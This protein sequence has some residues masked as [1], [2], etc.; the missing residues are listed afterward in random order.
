MNAD[1]SRLLLIGATTGYQTRTFA[2]AAERLGYELILATDRCHILDDPWADRAL[3]LRFEDPQGAAQAMAKLGGIHGI[4]AVG[5]RPAY[6]AALAAEKLGMAYNSVDSVAAC[7][8]K[9]LAHERFRAA[10]LLVPEYNR[11]PISDGPRGS[12]F[13]PC[14]LKPLGLSASRGVIRAN[15]PAEFEAA[16]RRIEKLLSDPDIARLRDPQNEF[17]QVESFIEGREFALEGILTRGQFRAL[18]I[19]DKPDPLDGPF[20]EETIYV[21]PSRENAGTQRAIIETTEAAVR[22]L[23]LA[24]GP[25]HAE[26][27]VNARGVWMLEVAARPIGGLCS[28][29]LPGLEELILRHAAGEDVSTFPLRE[30]AAGVMMIP[31]AQEG[32]YTDVTGFEAARGIDLIEEVI[33]TAKPG[34]KVA[35]LPEGSSYLGF[36][37]AR[38]ADPAA[39]EQALRKSYQQLEFQILTALPVI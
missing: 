7:R 1:K 25:V 28:R 4:V 38:G 31:I 10:G 20:F 9:F 17:I 37:F 3:P 2:E 6:L 36:I 26:M 27:R 15:N 21:T 11:V 12:L 18:A 14:V 5:D 23:G 22:S 24:H 29:V 34:Q 19:F 33:I 30:E 8:D 32:I 16:F 13:Y 39:V 35:P